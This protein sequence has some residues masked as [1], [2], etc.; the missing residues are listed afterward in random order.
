[1]LLNARQIAQATNATFVVEPLGSREVV[2]GLVWDSREVGEGN[3]YV[4]LPGERVDGHDFVD[5][6]LRAGAAAALVMQTPAEQTCALA[7]EL[8]AGILQVADT[9]AAITDLAA[10]W[11]TML[12]G[13]VIGLTGSSGKT[14]TKNLVRDVLSAQYSVVATKANQNNELGVPKTLLNAD[15]TTDYVVVE[16]GMRGLNQI[17][18]LCDF[19]K[20]HMGLIVNV[21][22]SH[23]E[24]L[25]GREN[26]ARAKGEL[27]EAL[28]DNSGVA[29]VNGSCDYAEFMCEHAQLRSRNV[30]EVRFGLSTAPEGGAA[31]WAEDVHLD[32]QG[33]PCF[34]LCAQ[35]FEQLEC[36]AGKAQVSLNLRGLHNVSNATAAAAVGLQ[37]GMM[38]ETVASA[39]A[40]AEPEAG[41]QQVVQASAGYT[42]VDDAYNANP[43]SM[44]ASLLTFSA[45]ETPGRHIAVLGD[46]GEL[47][48]YSQAC[49]EGIGA[50]I[51]ALNV[52][53]LIC[54]GEV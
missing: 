44:R 51:P 11:R 34:T 4:A 1:M 37:C 47:G 21:G 27:F 3:I 9:T 14:T 41:R 25:G 17:R 38:L 5:A 33:R 49:H 26:I 32:Q 24:L 13:T 36:G 30:R 2:N 29:F 19:V 6:A 48:S 53:Y 45:M 18:P 23:I 10:A 39:L 8:G 20:P 22:E 31:V 28:P 50:L 42:V 52:E 35:G 54:L 16:M 15:A 7:R 40:A 43:E 12:S 46:M